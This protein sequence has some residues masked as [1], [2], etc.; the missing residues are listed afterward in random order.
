VVSILFAMGVVK[1]FYIH[2]PVFNALA[3]L[4]LFNCFTF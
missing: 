4:R 1:I 3:E 2:V